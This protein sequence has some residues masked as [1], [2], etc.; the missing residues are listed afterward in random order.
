LHMT[1]YPKVIL[2]KGKD[3]A[4]R[5]FHPW[6]FSGAIG[7]IRG[8][9]KEGDIVEV[10]SAADD[11]L[12]T[13]YLL[14]GSI[15][16]KLFTFSKGEIDKAFWK[17]KLELAY[18]LRKELGLAGSVSTN[19]YRLVHNE[20]DGMPGLT[21]DI[22]GSMAV[23]QAHSVGM[24][25]LREVICEML[26]EVYGKKL[27]AVY[28]KSAESLRKMT[29]FKVEDAFLFGSGNEI[30][31]KENGNAFIVETAS[32]QKTGFF[33]DQR[34]NRQLL[35]RFSKGRKVLN[36][37]GYTGGFS[38]YAAKSGAEL[39]H[40]VDSSAP[41]I[42]MA[43]RNM[44]LNQSGSVHEGIVADA[45]TFMPSIQEGFYDLIVLDP[46]AYAKNLDAKKQAL[47]AY[48][49][50]NLQAMKKIAP[51]GILFT[52]SCSQVVDRQMFTSAVTAA[53]IDSGR[54]VQVLHQ[55]SQPADHP[56]SIFHQEGIYLK[57][58]V[59]RVI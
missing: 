7:E 16:I 37:F 29:G 28:D 6:I 14:S 8:N 20:G 2:K 40:T 32:G 42:A 25:Q 46:P 38:V 36:M 52:F 23:L 30:Q 41:A 59:L 44:E 15:A 34:E 57:G 49:A 24:Y 54:K 19:A 53:A 43:I 1:V 26:L 39:V 12:A 22:Y 58:L 31:V 4:V 18:N 17:S 33:L 9:Y 5:R 10:F 45:R 13:G 55:L 21:I 35:T 3:E 50:I 56:I 51:E 48:R 11:Y 47:N 27:K